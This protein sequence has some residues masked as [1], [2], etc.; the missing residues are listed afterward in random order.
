M[1]GRKQLAY[2]GMAAFVA[3]SVTGLAVLA[4]PGGPAQIG[5]AGTDILSMMRARSPGDRAEGA[6][7]TKRPVQMAALSRPAS[8]AA[9]M[10]AVRPP[11]VAAPP[12]AMAAP[13]AVAPIAPAVAGA[14]VVAAAPIASGGFPAA[15]G[16][17][18]L[19]LIPLIGGDGDDGVSPGITQPPTPAIPEPATWMMMILGFGI[20]GSVMRRR[21]KLAQGDPGHAA[22]S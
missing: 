17:A 9:P 5:K 10:A 13:A 18:I 11:P 16:L 2:Y 15:A 20:L 14:P 1:N 8:K 12:V 6:Q 4:V 22:I 3:A 21:R 19:P 7:T